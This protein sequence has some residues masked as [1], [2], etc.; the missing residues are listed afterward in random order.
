MK[1]K[2]Q[3]REEVK[4]YHREGE[5]KNGEIYKQPPSPSSS[6]AALLNQTNS[7]HRNKMNIEKRHKVQERIKKQH[8]PI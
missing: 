7:L 1:H 6:L 2:E 5:R 4:L 8:K 3:Q